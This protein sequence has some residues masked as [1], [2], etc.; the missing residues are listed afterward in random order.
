MKKIKSSIHPPV[1]VV[2]HGQINQ[3]HENETTV[4]AVLVMHDVAPMHF[5]HAELQLQISIFE[6]REDVARKVDQRLVSL[7]SRSWLEVR[8]SKRGRLAY[9]KKSE[10]SSW[11]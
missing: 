3:V 4:V 2:T 11:Q 9:P 5:I 8:Q 6:S 1:A 10:G 7:P